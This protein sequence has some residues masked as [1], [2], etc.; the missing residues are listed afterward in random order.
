MTR[1]G[2]RPPA[3]VQPFFDVLGEADTIRFLF[4]FGG[5]VLYRTINPG[6]KSRLVEMF[7]HDAAVA[8]AIAA[9]HAPARIPTAKPWIAVCWAADGVAVNEIARR[10]H[11]TDVTVRNWLKRLVDPAGVSVQLGQHD[12]RQPRLI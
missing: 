3:H 9:E 1:S 11:V 4:T 10:L 2:P 12:P 5:A 7:G 8:I 6:A